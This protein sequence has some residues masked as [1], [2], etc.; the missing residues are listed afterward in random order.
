M[1][2]A[3]FGAGMMS[4]GL[5]FDL[6]KNN[7]IEKVAV[8]E[9]DSQTLETFKKRFNDKRLDFICI[10]LTEFGELRNIVR[11]FSCAVN[12]THYKFNYDLS[13]L[14][15]EQGVN[16]TDMGGNND[17]VRKQLSLNDKAREKKITIIPDCGLAPGMANLSA[18]YFVEDYD[19]VE[20]LKIR[21]GGVPQKPKTALNYQ[22]VFS[23][24]GLINEY[25]E[26]AIVLRDGKNEAVDSMTEVET[27]IFDKPFGKMEAFYTSGGTSTLPD[28][29]K[30]KVKNLDYKTI[31]YPGHCD[32]FRI[33]ID[34]GFT[35][36]KE[37]EVD[38]KK[39][40]PRNILGKMLLDYLPSNEPD[41]VLVRIEVEGRKKGKNLKEI[42]EI[43][44]LYDE[45]N[46]LS[47][48]QRTT[49]FPVSIIA[50]M[51]AAGQI[52]EKGVVPQEISVPKKEYVAELV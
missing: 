48:M 32:L 40:I 5:V 20:S 39:I 10:D 11:D 16:F 14:C 19:D 33:F 7:K 22:L 44:D 41:A 45:K 8:V 35:S 38:G 17:V 26:K 47:A 31:R 13:R 46:A 52:S 30:N 9:K 21:V 1:K 34:S 15:I 37:I 4:Q 18:S 23:V 43:I 29:L 51:L 49:S 28:T 2:I 42:F 50:Q 27:L 24:E 25:I 12:A 6:L 3:V 36:S